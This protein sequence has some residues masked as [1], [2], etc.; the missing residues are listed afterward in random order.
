[1]KRQ[2][3]EHRVAGVNERLASAFAVPAHHI[4]EPPEDD[5]SDHERKAYERRCEDAGLFGDAVEIVRVAVPVPGEGPEPEHHGTFRHRSDDP[6]W[7]EPAFRD[8]VVASVE[9][10]RRRRDAVSA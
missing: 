10:D 7:S 5:G 8:A 9:E 2:R 6:R 3:H 4:A 1:M